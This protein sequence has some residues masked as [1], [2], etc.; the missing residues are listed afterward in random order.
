MRIRATLAVLALLLLA[1]CDGMDPG[2]QI[3]RDLGCLSCHGGDG[4]GP[5]WNGELGSGRLL[6]DGSTVLFD[7][8]Y[9]R[10][11]IT[12]PGAEVVAGYN[13]VM[14]V[15]SLSTADEDALV[16]YVMKVAGS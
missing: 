1:A 7:E 3:A 12:N 9:V 14:P 11:S 16:R 6:V 10:R 5:S 8:G 4:I 13:E 2:E 15:Y